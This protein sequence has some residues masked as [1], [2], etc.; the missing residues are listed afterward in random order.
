MK[1]QSKHSRAYASFSFAGSSDAVA[2]SQQRST[3]TSSYISSF[4][5]QS[6]A[7]LGR[8]Y[9]APLPRGE[10]REAK[11]HRENFSANWICLEVVFVKVIAP[12]KGT[13]VPSGLMTAR[14]SLG[15]V[16]LARLM[17]LKKSTRNCVLKVSEILITGM[18]LDKEKSNST[19]PGPISELRPSLPFRVLIFGGAK[20]W[21]LTY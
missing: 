4:C 7:P 2:R 18:F 6:H 9:E 13:G 1:N 20:H 14:L 15:E 11:S 5:G 16:K 3:H 19:S 12:P 8:S 17:I 10:S 21:S